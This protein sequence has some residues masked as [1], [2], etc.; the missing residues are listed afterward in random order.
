[1]FSSGAVSIFRGGRNIFIR[2]K[3][4]PERCENNY[5]IIAKERLTL[6]SAPTR[7]FFIRG[8]NI[9]F[10]ILSW[11]YSPLIWFT[12]GHLHASVYLYFWFSEIN[13]T[14]RSCNKLV[15]SKIFQMLNRHRRHY[16]IWY[17]ILK[18][19]HSSRYKK[20]YCKDKDWKMFYNLYIFHIW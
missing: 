20:V 6:A 14:L 10:L 9:R 11:A 1:M 17:K 5:F 16:S 7:A 13:F 12:R 4:A 15:I 3:I 19:L 2:G 18:C 8:R